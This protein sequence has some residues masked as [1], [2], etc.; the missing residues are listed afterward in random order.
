INDENKYIG[1]IAIPMSARFLINDGQHRRAAIE[2]ALK[3]NPDLK[4]EHISVVFYHDLGLKRSQQMFSDLNRF[5]IRPTKSLNILYDNRDAFSVLV[6]EVSEKV[7]VFNG[8]VDKERTTIPNRS[9]ALFTLSA[10]YHG[11]AALLK[12]LNYDDNHKKELA[13]EYWNEIGKYIKEWQNVKA[14]I[15]KSSEVRKNYICSLGIT[16]IAF[17]YAGNALL[18][19]YPNNWKK[20]VAKLASVD[21]RKSNPQW[22]NTIVVNGSV[23]ASRATQQTLIE[24]IQKVFFAR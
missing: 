2:A 17:G 20:F 18:K 4:Y 8:L 6:K 12:D 5:A 7:E 23:V 3:K 14:G 19:K 16:I 24:Y 11:T 10:I 22:E 15:I 13:I 1:E 21:W 9:K